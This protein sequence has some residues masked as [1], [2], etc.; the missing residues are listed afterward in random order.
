MKVLIV[1]DDPDQALLTCDALGPTVYQPTVV[2]TIAD[3]KAQKWDDFGLI[4]LDYQLPDGFGLDLITDIRSLTDMPVIMITGESGLAVEAVKRGASDYIVKTRDHL[5]T[6]ALTI[7][8]NI[9]QYRLRQEK[10]TLKRDLQNTVL[11]LQH[12]NDQLQ[13]A[14][15]QLIEA[16]KLSAVAQ[17][18]TG[19]AHE[20][21][22]PLTGIIGFSELLKTN[23]EDD[24]SR[25][26]LETIHSLALRCAATVKALATFARQGKMPKGPV[27]INELLRSCLTLNEHNLS[28]ND[29]TVESILSDDIP[30]VHGHAGH[31]QQV[32]INII[33]N[34][35]Q[36][37]AEIPRQRKLSVRTSFLEN[38]VFV[39]IRDNGRGMEAEAQL[40]AFEPFFTTQQVGEGAGLGLSVTYGIVQEHGGNISINSTPE[41]GTEVILTFPCRAELK[42]DFPVTSQVP[43][44]TAVDSRVAI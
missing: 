44:E 10:D 20:L 42:T 19:V 3:C 24:S 23:L 36:A 32:F 6:L 27:G 5:N 14:Q 16:A 26:M 34:S 25:S 43:G 35:Q 41:E 29:I 31:L 7:D 37:L 21:N 2:H 30:S 12:K 9:E 38:Q 4:L 11:E 22:N 28:R 15:R 1:E 8:K 39:H 18:V 40:H 13:M 17:L 33:K